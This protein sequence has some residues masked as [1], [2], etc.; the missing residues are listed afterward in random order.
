MIS[1]VLDGYEKQTFFHFGGYDNRRKTIGLR[2]LG[3][4]FR[5]STILNCCF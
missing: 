1:F 5:I 4:V 3:S 2:I